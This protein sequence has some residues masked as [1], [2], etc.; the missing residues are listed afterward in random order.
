VSNDHSSPSLSVRSIEVGDVP[1]V[2]EIARANMPYPWSRQTFSDCMKTDYHGW[3]VSCGDTGLAN[4]VMGYVMT[5]AQ[6]DEC[7]ILNICVRSAH[8]RKG[9]ALALM[10]Q[11]IDFSWQQKLRRI[12]L[13][14]RVSNHHAI[15]FYRQLNFQQVG[16]RR[17][18]YPADN[19]REDALL[20]A[21]KLS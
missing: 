4:Q 20:L 11:V 17:D 12:F 8:R 14:V 5:L 2:S 18:Y 19:G 6:I 9:Y 7:Q 3:L 13:E 10:Q 1:V 15:A 21:L 16:L